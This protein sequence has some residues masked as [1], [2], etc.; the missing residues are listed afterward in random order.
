MDKDLIEDLKLRLIEGLTILAGENV[1]DGFGHLSARIPGTDTFLINPRY[2]GALADVEDICTVDLN[3]KRV[4]GSRP[5]PSETPIHT[6]VYRSRPDVNSVIHCHPHYS[7]IFGLTGREIVPFF[8]QAGI[9][10]DG[11]PA[12]PESAI[13]DTRELADRMT[14]SLGDHRVALLHGHGIVS[15]GPTIETNCITA[16]QLER[17]CADQLLLMQFT[18]PEPLPDLSPRS[19]DPGQAP[20]S[21][22]WPFLQLKHGVKSR[23]QIKAEMR[24]PPDPPGSV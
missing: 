6:A 4:A 10:A 23:E 7:V 2:P 12:F 24:L 21:R 15:A 8:R 5:I 17:T 3:G 19:N 11:V 16:I 20:P 22:Y 9:L 14:R 13:I 18:A 1:M